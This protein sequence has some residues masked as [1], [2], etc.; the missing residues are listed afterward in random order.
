MFLSSAERHAESFPIVSSR[1]LERPVDLADLRHIVQTAR[2]RDEIKLNGG[3]ALGGFQHFEQPRE[4]TRTDAPAHSA[5]A[6]P[7]LDVSHHGPVTFVGPHPT[8]ETPGLDAGGRRQQTQGVKELIR[9]RRRRHQRNSKAHHAR[10]KSSTRT[11]RKDWVCEA[12]CSC[13]RSSSRRSMRTRTTGAGRSSPESRRK[14]PACRSQRDGRW[15][16]SLAKR[17]SRVVALRP[18]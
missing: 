2:G 1:S 3:R 14:P 6:R 16:P 17:V 11:R 9:S 5:L 10:A 7:F 4:P 18:S 13:A 12:L 15:S 8:R